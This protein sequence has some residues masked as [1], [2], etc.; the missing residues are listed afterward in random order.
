MDPDFPSW[1][2]DH[3]TTTKK[4]GEKISCLTF[5]VAIS[6][7]KCYLNRFELIDKEFKYFNPKNCYLAFR[8]MILGSEIRDREP[9]KIYPIPDPGSG[10]ESKKS[11]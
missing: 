1:I 2:P 3:T 9:E 7:T 8:N 6:L 11:P 10:S 5:F 4:G